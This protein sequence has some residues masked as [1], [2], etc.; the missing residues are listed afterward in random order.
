MIITGGENVLPGEIESVLSLHPAVGEVAVCGLPHER[1][2][3]AVTAFI[4]AIAPVTE[5][6][7][8]AWCLQSSLAGFKRPRRYM[9]VTAIP[10]SPVGKI[11][12]RKLIAGE[13]ETAPTVPG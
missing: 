7:L 3:Q 10:K 4:K 2:G 8:D 13:F 6:E 12:R 5:A 1:L 9:F 11:L